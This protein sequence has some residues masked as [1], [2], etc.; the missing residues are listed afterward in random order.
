[1]LCND[2]CIAPVN[3]VIILVS[4]LVGI[5]NQLAYASNI[6][7]YI[8]AFLSLYDSSGIIEQILIADGICIERELRS[9]AT[10]FSI[11]Q[12]VDANPC[13]EGQRFFVLRQTAQIIDKCCIRIGGQALIERNLFT[14]NPHG[15]T[16]F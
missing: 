13:T 9:V 2:F 14:D 15:Q 6:E 16:C 11:F 4:E 5:K 10:G 7:R 12:E 3:A 1:M 8:F